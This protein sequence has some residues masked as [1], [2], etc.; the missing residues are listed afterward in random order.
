MYRLPPIIPPNM[1]F[2]L[3]TTM[4]QLPVIQNSNIEHQNQQVPST[5]SSY[6][7]HHFWLRLQTDLHQIE[8]D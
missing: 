8:Y 5:V 4:Y 7:L 3:P 2:D 1:V 6:I